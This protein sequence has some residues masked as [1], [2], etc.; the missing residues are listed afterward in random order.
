MKDD[1]WSVVRTLLANELVTCNLASF[2]SWRIGGVS[3]SFHEAH[4]L[5]VLANLL[6]LWRG[7]VVP[8]GGLSNL[9]INDQGLDNSCLLVHFGR[10]FSRL[11][12]LAKY[13]WIY[14]EAGVRLGTMVNFALRCKLTD[15]VFLAGIPGTVGGAVRMNAGA[16]GD[17]LWRHLVAVKVMHRTG[18]C[19]WY[20]SKHFQFG[21]RQVDGLAPDD[22]VV[23]AMLQF[24]MGD[25]QL[26]R[27]TMQQQLIKRRASQ[28]LEF[29][30]CGC[31]FRN[32]AGVYA[33]RLI[34]QCG[35]KGYRCG[36]AEIST[37][38]ANF[39]VNRDRA[40]SG[41]ILRL[42]RVIQ[43]NVKERYKIDLQLEIKLLGLS[44]DDENNY[45]E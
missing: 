20:T 28:P 30:N 27:R 37:K 35:M 4:N 42:I 24:R 15:A 12:Y 10:N 1:E 39:I 16:H 21:Y 29:A 2:S 19:R 34:E 38:H 22:L 40:T 36:G 8:L 33:A 17:E 31:V 14:A 26:A 44:L 41:D 25:P 43:R 3:A 11:R 18:D 45:E 23:A 6:K 9:L 5:L 7:S 32:P 13:N